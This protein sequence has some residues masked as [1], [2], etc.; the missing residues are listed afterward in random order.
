M[1]KLNQIKGSEV[2]LVTSEETCPGNREG[3][4]THAVEASSARDMN[5][6]EE[7]SDYPP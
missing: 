5:V 7:I 4:I 2:P 6:G 3:I 1:N